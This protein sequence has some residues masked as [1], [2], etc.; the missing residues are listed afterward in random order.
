MFYFLV[1]GIIEGTTPGWSCNWKFMLYP[2]EVANALSDIW[3]SRLA[4]AFRVLRKSEH[5]N[6]S[7]SYKQYS[8]DST[9]DF[10]ECN[11]CHSAMHLRSLLMP[12][13]SIKAA[14]F[15]QCMTTQRVSLSPHVLTW[16]HNESA[17]KRQNQSLPDFPCLEAYNLAILARCAE[18]FHKHVHG[19]I[20]YQIPPKNRIWWFSCQL[21]F[22]HNK[23]KDSQVKIGAFNA[24]QFACMAKESFG[25]RWCC[26]HTKG[27]GRAPF[28]K[29]KRCSFYQFL[30]QWCAT[31]GPNVA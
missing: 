14:G 22:K 7:V 4:L 15:W 24:V 29:G 31:R 5:P 30:N 27:S 16:R 11:N 20:F 3:K 1:R 26:C 12:L 21:T 19:N 2:T 13:S 8:F 28:K 9:F 10:W 25:R 17:R 23:R 6:T 18:K